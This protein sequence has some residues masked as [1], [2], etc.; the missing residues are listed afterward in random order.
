V[1]LFRLVF[2]GKKSIIMVI[3]CKVQNACRDVKGSFI[4]MAKPRVSKR[5]RSSASSLS[6]SNF[7]VPEFEDAPVEL[8]EK[9]MKLS[10][11]RSMFVDKIDLYKVPSKL[12]NNGVP[13]ITPET[14]K[15][16]IE[17]LFS[18]LF[19]KIIIIDCR[20]PY[21][22]DGGHIKGA[23]NITSIDTL[24]HKFFGGE[25]IGRCCIVF[26]CEFSSER[27]PKFST[28]FR[29]HDRSLNSYP[30]ANYQD[31]YCLEGG[32]SR[33]FEEY[34]LQCEG[35][36]VKMCD[37]KFAN[38]NKLYYSLFTKQVEQYMYSHNEFN[39]NTNS[40]EFNSS[41]IMSPIRGRSTCLL[42]SPQAS[43]KREC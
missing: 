24:L 11:T 22:F 12:E 23:I 15:D 5:A 21:E 25:I 4:L 17:G 38:E 31:V 1:K 34:P 35:D 3:I 8:S 9:K 27:A 28:I 40:F 30:N 13:I 18:P 7:P 19:D 16:I 14:M 26:H 32:Y 20:F 29:K 33:F 6:F 41:V 39:H 37:P 42:S 2:W 43:K 36:Y 10:R